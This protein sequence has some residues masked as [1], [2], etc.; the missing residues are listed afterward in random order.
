MASIDSLPPDQRAVLQLVLQRGRSY[1]DIAAML[2]IDRAAV[3]QRALDAFDALGPSTS[4]ATAQRALLTDYLLGQLPAKVADQVRDRLASSPPDRGW[5]RVIASEIA[6]LSTSPLPEI[7]VGGARQP[8]AEE[9]SVVAASAEPAGPPTSRR[10]R[11]PAVDEAAPVRPTLDRSGPDRGGSRPPSSRRGGAVL[12]GLVGVVVI[13]VIV[14]LV[15]SGGSSKPK[16]QT[17][18]SRTTGTTTTGTTSTTTAT[19]TPLFQVNLV[20]PAGNKNTAGVAVVERE[21]T[22][23]GIALRASGVP[24]NTASTAYGV[25]LSNSSTDNLLVGF[26]SQRVGKTGVLETAGGLP[27][28][29]SKFKELIVSV[30][31]PGHT[32][33]P[34]Q[35]VLEGAPPAGKQF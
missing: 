12:L 17:N 30:Q 2:S 19:A 22:A 1:D 18:A 24:A 26:V 29:A 3:R 9:P 6:S 32:K 5:A 4:V 34:G 11:S 33:S 21:G 8:A 27:P 15:T 13:V 25:W 23:D 16:T 31:T 28:G 10:T 14:L 20:S 7:P 35:I